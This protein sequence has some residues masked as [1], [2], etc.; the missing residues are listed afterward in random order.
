[1]SKISK[2]SL[3]SLL[4]DYFILQGKEFHVKEIS[5]QLKEAGSI[6]E[7]HRIDRDLHNPLWPVVP[8]IIMYK[9][10]LEEFKNFSCFYKSTKSFLFIHPLNLGIINQLKDELSEFVDINDE[11][12]IPLNKQVIAS[13]YGGYRWHEPYARAC[14]YLKTLDCS[15]R[16]ITLNNSNDEKIE[17]L[18]SYKN[19]NRSRLSEKIV[20]DK[21]IINTN[22]DGMINSFHSPDQIENIRQLLALKLIDFNGISND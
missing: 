11:I 22:M 17:Q 9:F 7:L 12:D 13:L 8:Q 6:K 2:D 5:E 10:G 3:P 4:A 15:A 14:D 1:M 16:I 18:I 19:Q 21:K 20:I